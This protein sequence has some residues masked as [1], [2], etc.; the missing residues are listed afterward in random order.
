MRVLEKV[1]RRIA[2][3]LRHGHQ[4]HTV[5]HIDNSRLVVPLR[6][7]VCRFLAAR[8]GHGDGNLPAGLYLAAF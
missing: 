4:Y 3:R 6:Q 5:K 2:R 8:C 1:A 7:S